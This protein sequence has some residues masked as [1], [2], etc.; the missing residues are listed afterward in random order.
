MSRAWDKENSESPIGFEPMTCQTPGGRSIL[1]E[2]NVNMSGLRFFLC[3]KL[4]TCWLFHFL[5]RAT[6]VK[7]AMSAGEHAR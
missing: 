4:V 5:K 6:S 3:P 1:G 7:G 2:T